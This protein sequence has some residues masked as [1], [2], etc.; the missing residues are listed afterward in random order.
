MPPASPPDRQHLQ[1]QDQ[2]EEAMYADADAEEP[3]ARQTAT[4]Q[5]KSLHLNRLSARLICSLKPLASG[6]TGCQPDS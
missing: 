5:V 1:H 3:P 6:S 2:Q 4:R